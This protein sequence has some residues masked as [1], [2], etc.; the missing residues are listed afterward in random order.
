MADGLQFR[1]E[2]D[3]MLFKKF[4]TPSLMRGSLEREIRKATIRNSLLFIKTVARHVRDKPFEE[5]APLTLVLAGKKTTPLL[6]EKNML[7]A[8][9]FALR[10]SFE[11]EVGFL[12]QSQ[13]TGGVTGQTIEMKRLVE[14]MHTG[15][16]ITVTPKMIAA[17]MASLRTQKTKKGRLK[18]RAKD[19]LS[20]FG[21][22]EGGGGKRVFRVPPRP[23]IEDVVNDS[24]LINQMRK[25]WSEA[26][27]RAFKRQGAKGGDERDR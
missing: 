5:N 9:S 7:D 23:F 11:S 21:G 16:T 14:L 10:N 17:I 4:M 8:M 18:K 13:S 3:M 22:T 26:L 15:Y 24:D 12:K 25:N 2:G 1:I 20:I 19:A 6:K 27:E